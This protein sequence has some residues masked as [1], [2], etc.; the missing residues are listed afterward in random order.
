ML[1]K[2]NEI[3][4]EKCGTWNV[5]ENKGGYLFTGN[6]Y[7]NKKDMI[8]VAREVALMHHWTSA[9]GRFVGYS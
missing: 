1:M 5:I 8:D 9:N 4:A 7:E 3:I 6:V 2:T